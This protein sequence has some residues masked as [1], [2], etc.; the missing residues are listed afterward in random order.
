MN[1]LYSTAPPLY[2]SYEDRP[3]NVWSKI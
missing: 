2:S 1:P 3:K